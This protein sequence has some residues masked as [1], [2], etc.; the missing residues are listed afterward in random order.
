[1]IHS[2]SK[3]NPLNDPLMTDDENSDLE[4][5]HED[6]TMGGTD[7]GRAEGGANHIIQAL[8]AQ[9][10]MEPEKKPRKQSERERE[11]IAKLVAKYGEDTRGMSRDRKLNPMQ[12]T[13]A[14]I[15]RRVK[16]WRGQISGE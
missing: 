14:D 8:E 6:E 12:Q 16:K 5:E 1:M 10:A 13:E 9:A 2:G 3:P 4:D 15:A 11:W 7:L